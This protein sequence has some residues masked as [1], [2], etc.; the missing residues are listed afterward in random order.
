[1]TDQDKTQLNA[2]VTLLVTVLDVARRQP[3]KE[4]IIQVIEDAV[5]MARMASKKPE[6]P[7]DKN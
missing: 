7:L 1:M 3:D 4:S 6:N 2:A 5:V